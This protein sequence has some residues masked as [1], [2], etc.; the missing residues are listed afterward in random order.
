MRK[1]IDFGP[2]ADLYDVYVQWDVDV[3]FFRRMCAPVDSVLEL[4]AGTGRLSIPLLRAGVRL[5]CAD[6]SAAMLDVLRNK[7]KAENLRADVEQDVRMLDIPQRF[8]R[9]LLPFHSFS[10]LLDPQDRA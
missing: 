2:V 1:N 3:P 7:L 4:M 9:V 8:A 5:T 10:E 6:Y